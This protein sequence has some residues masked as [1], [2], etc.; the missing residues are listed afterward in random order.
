MVSGCLISESELLIT[1]EIELS[2]LW[3]LVFLSL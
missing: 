3:P 1:D 2:L